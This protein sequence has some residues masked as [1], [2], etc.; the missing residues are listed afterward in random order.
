MNLKKLF[1][2]SYYCPK[3]AFPK[4]NVVSGFGL[5]LVSFLNFLFILYLSSSYN[6]HNSNISN[7]NGSLINTTSTLN[8]TYSGKVINFEDTR[9]IKL[10]YDA[11]N[12]TFIVV[13]GQEKGY[14]SNSD[15]HNKENGDGDRDG[16]HGTISQVFGNVSIKSTECDIFDGR[17]VRDDTKPYYEA[18]SCRYVERAFN[19]HRN[20]RPD[21]DFVKWR[22]QPYGCEIPRY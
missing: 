18:G 14:R 20:K 8:F 7:N 11:I 9:K 1:A 17:W 22:W 15:L 10:N 2:V 5:A 4:A 6:R 21:N 16:D 13:T 19:C 12:E 3:C